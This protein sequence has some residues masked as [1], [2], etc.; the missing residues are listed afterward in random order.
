MYGVL[1]VFVFF[2]IQLFFLNFLS[3]KLFL[4]CYILAG[5]HT[6]GSRVQ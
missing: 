3:F 6:L 4:I 5:V 2:S 1:I